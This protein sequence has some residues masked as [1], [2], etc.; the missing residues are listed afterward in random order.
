MQEE[1]CTEK[2]FLAGIKEAIGNQ[3]CILAH[4]RIFPD[5]RPARYQNPHE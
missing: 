3:T 2:H 5:T 1:K 4:L